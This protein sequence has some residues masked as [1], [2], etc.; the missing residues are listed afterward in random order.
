MTGELKRF[1]LKHKD[2]STIYAV[3]ADDRGEILAVLDMSTEAEKGGI[4]P[5]QLSSLPLVGRMT[6]SWSRSRIAGT[7]IT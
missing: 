6:S 4:C 7:P 5:H 2:L 1:Y 3:E